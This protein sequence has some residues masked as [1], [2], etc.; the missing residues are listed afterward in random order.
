MF[1]IYCIFTPQVIV[2]AI[3]LIWKKEIKRKIYEAFVSVFVVFIL[4]LALVLTGCS[5][6]AA[7]PTPSDAD[8]EATEGANTAG[9]VSFHIISH[10]CEYHDSAIVFPMLS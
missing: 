6:P 1:Y 3:D 2:Y 7:S 9:T 10:V 8:A 5:N 4:T